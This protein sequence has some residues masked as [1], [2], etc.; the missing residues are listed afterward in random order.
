MNAS[1]NCVKS[2]ISLTCEW[3]MLIH[4][5][6]LYKLTN[7]RVD[8]LDCLTFAFFCLDWLGPK[9]ISDYIFHNTTIIYAVR[10][11]KL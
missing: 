5:V 10:W 9:R 8:P 11:V 1:K 7:H 2:L 4:L 6:V 3:D